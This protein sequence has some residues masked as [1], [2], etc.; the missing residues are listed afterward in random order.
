[1]VFQ[2]E[3]DIAEY[4]IASVDDPR[5]DN[6]MLYILPADNILTQKQINSIWEQKIS[7]TLEKEV[8][9]E[10]EFLKRIDG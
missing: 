1:M 6:K 5:L 2:S 9:G 3:W 7:R 8:I 10:E 4:L